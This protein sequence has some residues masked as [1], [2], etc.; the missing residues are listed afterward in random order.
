[1]HHAAY[2]GQDSSQATGPLRTFLHN[3]CLGVIVL[4]VS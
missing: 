2:Q 1:M 4:T 3:S